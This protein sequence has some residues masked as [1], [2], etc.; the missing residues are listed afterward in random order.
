MIELEILVN[1]LCILFIGWLVTTQVI[2]PLIQGT[3]LFPIFSKKSEAIAEE[4]AKVQGEIETARLQRELH[5][6]KQILQEEQNVSDTTD[7]HN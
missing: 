1:L 7:T 2:I 5:R 4:I 6:A 3:H